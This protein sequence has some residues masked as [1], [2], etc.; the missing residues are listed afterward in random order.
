MKVSGGG[1]EAPANAEET[2]Q[3][4]G[5]ADG[6]GLLWSL[7]EYDTMIL[8]YDLSLGGI[9]V[10]TQMGNIAKPSYTY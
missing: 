9:T 2:G 10:T 3:S 6:I 4:E 5:K 7:V 1:S 8:S